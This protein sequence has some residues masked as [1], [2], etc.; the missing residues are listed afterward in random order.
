MTGRACERLVCTRFRTS[1]VPCLTSEVPWNAEIEPS[2]YNSS[3]FQ[4]L[5]RSKAALERCSTWLWRETGDR[6]RPAIGTKIEAFNVRDQFFFFTNIKE[7]HVWQGSTS[8]LTSIPFRGIPDVHARYSRMFTTSHILCIVNLQYL[9]LWG[10]NHCVV[11]SEPT[12]YR[13]RSYFA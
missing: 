5:S 4:C 8:W 1:E 2:I 13:E 9:G 6:A 12:S 11:S 10:I 7:V 3:Q